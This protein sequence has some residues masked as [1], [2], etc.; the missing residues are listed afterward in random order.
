[1]PRVFCFSY[2]GLNSR[3]TIFPES[4]LLGFFLDFNQPVGR[5]ISN[6]NTIQLFV[7]SRGKQNWEALGKATAQGTLIEAWHQVI[8]G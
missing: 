5:E 4:N 2:Q 1:M 8:G 7:S 6:Y 3:E